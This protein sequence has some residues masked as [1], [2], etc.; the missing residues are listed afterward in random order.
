[1]VRVGGGWMALDE[2]LVKNDPCR[3]RGRTN[4]ELREKFILPEGAQGLAAF[5][6]RGRRSKPGSRTASPT[7]SSSSASHSAHSCASLTSTPPTPTAS[8]S[9]SRPWLAHSKT[10]TASKCNCCPDQATP[11][12]EGAVSGSKLK[13]PTFHSS[14]GS[15]TGENGGSTPTSGKT[16]RTDPKR[17]GGATAGCSAASRAGSRAGSRRGSDASDASELQESR[18]VCSDT[19]D[20]PRRPGAKPSKIPTISKK[21]PSPKGPGPPKK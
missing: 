12:P 6:S 17:G 8:S 18:S 1:M 5:R 16:S 10:P 7:R 9:S 11:G 3:A 19:S 2:F 13:R 20:T 15:L 14:R 4:L 21:T